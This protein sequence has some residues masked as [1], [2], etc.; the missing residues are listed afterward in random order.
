MDEFD[1][2]RDVVKH[3]LGVLK[4]HAVSEVEGGLKHSEPSMEKVSKSP[5]EKMSEG[6]M[7]GEPLSLSNPDANG[8]D[9]LHH[10]DKPEAGGS[11]LGAEPNNQ[12]GTH[13]ADSEEDEES[14][15]SSFHH[16]MKRKK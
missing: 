6:G 7:A 3:L 16:L 13:H 5:S 12:D 4:G 14:N 15:Q 1:K 2:K 11:Q 9:G 10:S 8:Q